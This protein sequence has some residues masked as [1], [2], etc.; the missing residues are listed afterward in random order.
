MEHARLYWPRWCSL[1][2]FVV[3]A[4]CVRLIAVGG[5]QPVLSF[6]VYYIGV[7]FLVRLLFSA[8]RVIY[9]LGTFTKG[10]SPCFHT[11]TPSRSFDASSQLLAA[12]V[13]RSVV[14]R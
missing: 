9:T 3:S 7:H 11:V 5:K 1:C 10:E 2:L 14:S 8:F 12:R 13:C 4:R 6:C